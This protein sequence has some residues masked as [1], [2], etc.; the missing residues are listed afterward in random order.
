[1][2]TRLAREEDE[3]EVQGCCWRSGL[4]LEDAE[5]LMLTCSEVLTE[6]P[7]VVDLRPAQMLWWRRSLLVL[8]KE[9]VVVLEAGLLD[10]SS[11]GEE[12]L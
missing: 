7:A 12:L 8:S 5:H 4:T 3:G 10:Q 11:R 6:L 9:A 1:V 2:K